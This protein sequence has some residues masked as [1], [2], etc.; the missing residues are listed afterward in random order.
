MQT[1]GWQREQ[2]FM[3]LG[4]VLLFIVIVILKA[5]VKNAQ[6]FKAFVETTEIINSTDVQFSKYN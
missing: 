3:F 6:K 2:L 4:Y 5:A 1:N